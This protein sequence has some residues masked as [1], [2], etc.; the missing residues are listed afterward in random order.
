LQADH[1]TTLYE[2]DFFHRTVRDFILESPRQK[3]LTKRFPHLVDGVTC[4]RLWLA[5]IILAEPV[6]RPALWNHRIFS[7]NES[8][9]D[10]PV[11]LLREFASVVQDFKG[12]ILYFNTNPM[13]HLYSKASIL[14]L[15][16]AAFSGQQSYVLA[17]V[18]DNPKLLHSVKN[19][20][21]LLSTAMGGNPNLVRA[22]IEKGSSLMDRIEL[23]DGVN[24]YN[25]GC[26][27]PH[28]TLKINIT[29]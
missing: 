14:F 29:R 20:N 13:A 23:L 16:F 27:W 6:D 8:Q 24:K 11:N 15:H 2:V 28:R 10:L 21:V 25:F 18:K 12:H 3:Y 1:E 19:C 5:E 9:L 17:Q 26:L 7:F 22:L 4:F